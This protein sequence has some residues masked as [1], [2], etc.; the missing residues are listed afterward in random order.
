MKER[1]RGTA[2]YREDREKL[3]PLKVPRQPF[4]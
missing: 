1:E 4:R 2:F 3:R